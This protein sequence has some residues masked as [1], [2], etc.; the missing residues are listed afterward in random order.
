[1]NRPK[2][3]S[4]RAQD[5]IIFQQMSFKGTPLEFTK[6]VILVLDKRTGTIY[7]ETFHKKFWR[8]GKSLFTRA[9]MDDL[10]RKDAHCSK[11]LSMSIRGCHISVLS[12]F[13]TRISNIQATPFL[14]I[15]GVI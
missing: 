12:S 3:Y 6:N 13:W 11:C 5:A 4:Y 9:G 2:D 14:S 8:T 10:F 7:I 15:E 1:M